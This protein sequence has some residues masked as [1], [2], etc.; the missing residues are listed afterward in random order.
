MRL[1]CMSIVLISLAGPTYPIVGGESAW[2]TVR[3][4]RGQDRIHDRDDGS[5]LTFEEDRPRIDQFAKN[6]IKAVDAKG[7]V[8]AYGGRIG[9]RGEAKT[10]LRCISRYLARSYNI[11]MDRLVLVDGGYRNE[12]SVELFVVRPGD[13]IPTPQ[14]TVAAKAVRRSKAK[15][16]PCV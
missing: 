9:P 8:I 14:P 10:R 1:F 4:A 6:L 3:G 16:H 15:R 13:A 11:K 12:I 5:G 7:Y 2:V